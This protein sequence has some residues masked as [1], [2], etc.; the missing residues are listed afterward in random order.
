MV[1]LRLKNDCPTNC[2]TDV[3]ELVQRLIKHWPSQLDGHLH[4]CVGLSGGVDSVVLLHLLNHV[5]QIKPLTLS[6]VH[7]NHGLSPFA[8][9]WSEFCRNLCSTWGIPLIIESGQV[10]KEPAQGLEN[11]ARKFRYRVYA[12]VA[13]DAIVLA[14]HQDD[15]VETILSQLMRG[16]EIHN[17]SAMLELS[18]RGQKYF[19]RPLLKISKHQLL[20]YA[21]HHGLSHV[22]DESN[23]DTRYL[24]N[25]LR[26]QIIPQLV[27]Y[28]DNVITKIAG[29]I[30][31]LQQACAL[32]DE[33]AQLDLAAC[34][35][36]QQ[37]LLSEFCNLSSTRQINL[38]TY[39]VRQL[40]LP[41]PSK[42]Q[43]GEFARQ[44]QESAADRHPQ[45]VV[46]NK[47]LCKKRNVIAVY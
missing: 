44:L 25:F 45:L 20:E 28:D 15:Q 14:H 9:K 22:T 3:N 8:A 43:I 38:L 37:I 42:R 19:W 13:A 35:G 24:R 33:L 18:S 23:D 29:S 41:L 12:D 10:V 47:I 17:L 32:N 34:G 6:A 39:Y 46:G 36:P 21:H 7:V 2:A 27:A 4:L 31:A 30:S 1:N 26:N 40:Q 16:S 11:S 5:R